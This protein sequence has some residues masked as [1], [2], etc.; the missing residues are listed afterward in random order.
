MST[1]YQI[2]DQYG[3]YFLTFTIV[4]WVDVF[5]RKHYRDVFIDSLRFCIA[6]KG[7]RLYGYV[8]MSNHVHLIAA[9]NTGKLSETI[10][11]LKKYTA[12]NILNLIEAEPESR[13]EWMLHR[14]EWNAAQ[15][16]RNDNRQF[17]THENHAISI[18]SEAFFH[19]KLTYMH[20]N[21]VRAGWV[22][23]EEDYVYSS[24]G[25]LNSG[26]EG[27]VQLSYW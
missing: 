24:A 27:Q 1:G 18:T 14:F 13:R 22:D 25:A 10:R 9:S 26:K 20:Q 17:W 16:Q 23:R 12:R 5:I 11:D 7:L 15:A 3:M 2:Y 6:E 21:P 4:D 8:I 19:Q